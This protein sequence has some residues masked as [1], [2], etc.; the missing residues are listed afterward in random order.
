M[1]SAMAAAEAAAAVL[2]PEAGQ[3]VLQ[4]L[5]LGMDYAGSSCIGRNSANG[6]NPAMPFPQQQQ[7][8]HSTPEVPPTILRLY[9]E[10]AAKREHA[11]AVRSAAAASEARA[12]CWS[13]PRSGAYRDVTPRVFDHLVASTNSS[14]PPAAHGSTYTPV[15]RSSGAPGKFPSRAREE[16]AR[17]AGKQREQQQQ[18]CSDCAGAAPRR[19][20]PWQEFLQRQGTFLLVKEAK[21]AAA[22]AQLAHTQSPEVCAMLS[23][24][25]CA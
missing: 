11:E 14:S 21:V 3:A 4:G 17:A 2:G 6:P 10:A 9:E 15:R 18:L 23:E 7:Q 19:E 22:A 12:R 13:A 25:V 24:I 16:E 1:Q 5:L 20:E 8:Q